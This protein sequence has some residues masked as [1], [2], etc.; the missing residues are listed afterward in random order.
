MQHLFFDAHTCR[1]K[2]GEMA[3]LYLNKDSRICGICVSVCPIGAVKNI[4][5]EN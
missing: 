1:E 4:N 2:C 5:I 3:R